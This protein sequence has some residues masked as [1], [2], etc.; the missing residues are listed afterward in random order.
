MLVLRC[1]HFV[2]GPFLGAQVG[3]E[4]E[5]FVRFALIGLA[6][7]KGLLHDA[8]EF[9]LFRLLRFEL[10]EELVVVRVEDQHVLVCHLRERVI[11]VDDRPQQLLVLRFLHVRQGLWLLFNFHGRVVW[12]LH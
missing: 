3:V 4:D 1:V 7:V 9:R 2:I 11:R 10:L 6:L 12:E 5:L 8:I